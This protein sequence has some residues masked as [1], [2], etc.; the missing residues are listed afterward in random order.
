MGVGHVGSASAGIG[1]CWWLVV[2]ANG[3]H[4]DYSY[5]A[6]ATVQSTTTGAATTPKATA[7]PPTASTSR[8]RAGAGAPGAAAEAEAR[9]G[10]TAHGNRCGNGHKGKGKDNGEGG[11]FVGAGAPQSGMPRKWPLE[12]ETAW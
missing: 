12:G 6:T 8:G 7:Q 9:A 1:V 3:G 4:D 5:G 2:A 10:N 11:T